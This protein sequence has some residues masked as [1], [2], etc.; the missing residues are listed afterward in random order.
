MSM[1][2]FVNGRLRQARHAEIIGI[3]EFRIPENNGCGEIY[4]SLLCGRG[5]WAAD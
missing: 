3:P 5:N 1:L 4:Q 2:L